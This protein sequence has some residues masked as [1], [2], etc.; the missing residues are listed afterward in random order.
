[1]EN[2]ARRLEHRF[3]LTRHRVQLIDEG[4][5]TTDEQGREFRT[6]VFKGCAHEVDGAANEI[7]WVDILPTD[8]L[9]LLRTG[10]CQ[11]L[12]G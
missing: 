3:G 10:L 8:P 11:A 4:Q 2:R 7:L 12:D 9:D 1:L 6:E 5:E